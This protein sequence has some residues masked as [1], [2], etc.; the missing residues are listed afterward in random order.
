MKIEVQHG[1]DAVARDGAA[2]IA[3]DARAAVPARGRFIMETAI[4]RGAGLLVMGAYATLPAQ[5][6]LLGGVTVSVLNEPLLPVLMC[7]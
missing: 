1:D 6:Y 5:E 3:A 7:N 4:E 2:I